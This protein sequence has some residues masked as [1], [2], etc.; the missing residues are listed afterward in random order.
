MGTGSSGKSWLITGCSSGFGRVLAEQALARGDKV[1]VT[2]RRRDSIAELCTK[3]P[4]TALCLELDVTQPESV[5]A[6]LDEAVR[7]FGRIDVLVNNAGFG[8]QGAVEEFSDD[9]IRSMF[10]VNVFGV[11]DTIRAALPLMRKQGGGHIINI[12]SVGGRS[13]APLVSLYSSSKW[14]V[15]GLSMGLRMEVAPFGIK[16]TAVE[17]GAFATNFASS[18]ERAAHRLAVYDCVHEATDAMLADLEF[19]DPA[20]CAALI[21]KIADDPNPPGQ[22]IAGGQ[23]LSM[24]ED[25]VRSQAEE[26]EKWRAVSEAA[27]RE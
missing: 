7:K 24:I 1:A 3:Y 14:A 23:A 11:M 19:A 22:I 21:L 12:T 5:R 20:G 10:A 27:D 8:L 26:M 2:A 6:A 18:V 15:E 25:T 9:Q 4:D 17:P 16:V 13:S